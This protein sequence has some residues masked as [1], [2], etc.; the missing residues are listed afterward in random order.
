MLNDVEL[1]AIRLA[2]RQLDAYN[3][4]DVDAF[5]ACFSDDVEVRDFPSGALS[6]RSSGG[7]AFRASYAKFFTEKPDVRCNLTGRIV[8]GNVVMDEEFITGFPDGKT[9]RAVAI[10][11]T[12]EDKIFRVTFVS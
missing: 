12:R 10:Y 1:N 8:K 11:E 6:E 5:V 4:R 9:M 2:Q 3:A 7:A